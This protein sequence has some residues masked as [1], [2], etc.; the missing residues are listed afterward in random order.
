M[1]IEVMAPPG[2]EDAVAQ[3]GADIVNGA[4]AIGLELDYKGFLMAWIGSGVRVIAAK[5]EDQIV[6]LLLLAVGQRWLHNDF[7]SS[8]LAL[9]GEGKDALLD[10]AMN[11]ARAMGADK[12]FYELPGSTPGD[13]YVDR[14]MRE[15]ALQ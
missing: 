5:E 9:H 10:F 11:I 3:M 6:G 8:V 7:S 4:K 1:K 13:G 15:V 2:D 12:I 14:T